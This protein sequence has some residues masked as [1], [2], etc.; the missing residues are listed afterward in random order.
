MVLGGAL[1]PAPASPTEAPGLKSRLKEEVEFTCTGP[2]D[3]D[4]LG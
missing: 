3:L 2:P 4:G 1:T